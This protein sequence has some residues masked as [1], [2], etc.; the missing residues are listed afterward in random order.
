[1][2]RGMDAQER[3][4]GAR[5]G[6]RH[7]AARGR[8]GPGAR[9]PQSLRRSHSGDPWDA[10]RQRRAYHGLPPGRFGGRDRR[11][12]RYSSRPRA[13]VS[14]PRRR[15]I[16]LSKDRNM[17]DTVISSATKEV[18]IGFNRP[19]VIIGERINPTGRKVLAAEMAAG[20]FSRVEGDAT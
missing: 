10:R 11:S 8:P 1:K 17:T 2:D 15:E 7:R 9:R 19:F 16:R 6:C 4:G 20:D 12:I 13:L 3:S 18:V 5:A 14:R